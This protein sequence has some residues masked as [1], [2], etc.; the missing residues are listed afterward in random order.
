M[1]VY[2]TSKLHTILHYGYSPDDNG[3][4]EFTKAFDQLCR[5]DSSGQLLHFARQQH[6]ALVQQ[7]FGVE[8][9]PDEK[10]TL[11]QARHI[12]SVIALKMQS[13]DF[14]SKIDEAIVRLF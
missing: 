3:I 8:I 5:E 4:R 14:L 12:S 13:D 10:L 2:M 1:H 6:V 9:S 11:E 7:A